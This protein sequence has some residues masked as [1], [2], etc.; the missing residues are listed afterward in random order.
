MDLKQRDKI[1]NIRNNKRRITRKKEIDTY[2]LEI[3]L[4]RI[5]DLFVKELFIEGTDCFIKYNN[6]WRI[7]CRNWNASKKR[8]IQAN[9]SAFYESNIENT[10]NNNYDRPF[11]F[12]I[13]QLT[14][15]CWSF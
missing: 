4:E 10:K 2:E 3:E 8:T 5:E 11:N 1:I 9:E 14:N 6:M 13:P 15:V 12:S 7:F